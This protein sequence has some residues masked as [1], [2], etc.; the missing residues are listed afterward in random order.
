MVNENKHRG[1]SLDRLVNKADIT[2]VSQLI[3]KVCE[4]FA[5]DPLFCSKCE[6]L[7]CRYC[8]QNKKQK[9]EDSCLCEFQSLS[10]LP[11]GMDQLLNNIYLK[12]QNP[13]CKESMVYKEMMIHDRECLYN[14]DQKNIHKSQQ[15]IQQDLNRL[16]WKYSIMTAFVALL[17]I[18]NLF[19]YFTIHKKQEAPSAACN[20]EEQMNHLKIQLD[21]L[22]SNTIRLNKYATQAFNKFS[23]IDGSLDLIKEHVNIK[24]LPNIS[25]N[26]FDHVKSISWADGSKI[27]KQK[28]NFGT[29]MSAI[30]PLKDDWKIFIRI[31]KISG[32][33]LVGVIPHKIEEYNGIGL[34]SKNGI[35]EFALDLSTGQ[36][37]T[38]EGTY[39]HT[40]LRVK[41]GD[42][43]TISRSESILSF[44]INGRELESSFVTYANKFYPSVFVVNSGD[45]VEL[46]GYMDSKQD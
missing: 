12:C 20:F 24:N 3:C 38:P 10:P 31:N 9:S 36:L 23:Q 2:Q 40:K 29:T 42:V 26:L 35:N 44:S 33:I 25:L 39:N 13:P 37:L 5:R 34:F 8:S 1:I 11:A 30:K 14:P 15:K 45:E 22:N 27:L 32:V 6:S 43:I 4:R 21:S 16:K 28:A 18:T 19:L 46:L 41:E 17:V 7:Y